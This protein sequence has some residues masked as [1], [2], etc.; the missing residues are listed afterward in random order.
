MLI[1]P[2]VEKLREL[3]LA[4]MADGLVDQLQTQDVSSLSFEDRL[5]LLVDREEAARENRRLKT[6]LTQARLRLPACM[7]DIDYRNRRGLGKALVL[8]LASCQWITEHLNVVITGPTGVSV[9]SRAYSLAP[10]PRA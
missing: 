3:Q 6:R 8:S 5:G 7:E 1:H 10:D 2:T 4:G 9:R